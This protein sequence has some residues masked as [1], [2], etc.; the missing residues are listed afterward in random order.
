MP[1]EVA[2]NAVSRVVL[3]ALSV[4]PALHLSRRRAAQLGDGKDC[5]PVTVKASRDVGEQRRRVE[6]VH[7][8]RSMR[9]PWASAT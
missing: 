1:A 2:S 5:D 9:S 3:Y 8:E 4:A 6:Q 7:D